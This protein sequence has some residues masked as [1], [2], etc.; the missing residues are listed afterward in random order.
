MAKR[1][2]KS[3]HPKKKLSRFKYPALF[4]L[5]TIAGISGLFMINSQI[6]PESLTDDQILLKTEWTEEN[7]VDVATQRIVSKS[8]HQ[9]NPEVYRY[10]TEQIKKLPQQKQEEVRQ[11]I[12]QKT[13]DHGIREYRL[14]SEHKQKDM[15]D[16]LCRQAA[17]HRQQFEKNG[18]ANSSSK[19]KNLE[20]LKENKE[21][22]SELIREAMDKLTPEER[23]DLAP[24]AKEWV[25]IAEQ[26]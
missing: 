4:L 2:L 3:S 14:L 1:R 21:Q 9:G 23:K 20:R 22:A 19:D 10:V 7:I 26:L 12:M 11:K 5:L 13:V 15:V 6:A 25:K 18:S 8:H 16:K 17:R 24:L